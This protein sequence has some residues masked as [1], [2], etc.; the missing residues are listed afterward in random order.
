MRA[1]LT[2][3]VLL[4]VATFA[5]GQNQTSSETDTAVRAVLQAQVE[6]WNHRDLDAFMM[7]YWKSPNLT[8][9]SGAT[10]TQGWQST[11]DRYK[12]NYQSAGASM[13]TLSF[14]DLRVEPLA[15]DAAFVRGR[16]HL[17]MP[18]GKQPEGLF[19]LIFRKFPEGWRIVHD[20]SCAA[21]APNAS[22]AH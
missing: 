14:T 12:K 7:G 9:F 16:F 2:A 4:F 1:R 18:D 8:F 15:S 6:A 11:L 3:I 22:A 13:G 10:E 17:V 20:H 21:P 19:T 5:L